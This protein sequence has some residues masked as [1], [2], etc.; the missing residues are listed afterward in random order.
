MRLARQLRSR[1]EQLERLV[2]K[3]VFPSAANEL[4]PASPEEGRR[5]A[6]GEGRKETNMAGSA[7]QQLGRLQQQVTPAP[8]EHAAP[9][10]R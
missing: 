9:A 10:T 1:R 7:G 4:G 8:G 5:R 3:N 2:Q 6:A